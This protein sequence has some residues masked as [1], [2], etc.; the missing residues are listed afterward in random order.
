MRDVNKFGFEKWNLL[1]AMQ[2][3]NLILAILLRTSLSLFP[4]KY[5]GSEAVQGTEIVTKGLTRYALPWC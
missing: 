3:Q 5:S 4:N 1:S 2:R